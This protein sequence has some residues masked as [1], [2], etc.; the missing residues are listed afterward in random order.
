RSE[1]QV[2]PPRLS[3]EDLRRDDPT[4]AGTDGRDLQNQGV[5]DPISRMPPEMRA[6]YGLNR[7]PPNHPKVDPQLA[8][9]YGLMA[10]GGTSI[11]PPVESAIQ[12]KLENIRLSEVVFD[13]LPLS[14]VLKSLYEESK[15]RD[16]DKEGINFLITRNI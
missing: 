10:P 15:K 7:L 13:S 12:T 16:P 1:E 8:A 5:F 6:R 3:S 9:R 14:E 2:L 11:K 4:S